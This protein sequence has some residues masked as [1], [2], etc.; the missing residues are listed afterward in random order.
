MKKLDLYENISQFKKN[1]KI[2]TGV[3]CE[4]L[5][6]CL[7]WGGE[8][9]NMRKLWIMG[10]TCTDLLKGVFILKAMLGNRK[11]KRSIIYNL[12]RTLYDFY[13][14]FFSLL[15]QN[16]D[17]KIWH[18]TIW[19]T[20]HFYLYAKPDIAWNRKCIYV[21]EINKYAQVLRSKMYNTHKDTPN[22][23]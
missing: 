11:R 13:P 20:T 19:E 18:H 6:E 12:H 3:W 2:K 15:R 22:T 17:D 10:T 1:K 9:E 21:K 16:G 8:I 5:F 4:S 7:P 14:Q 23:L